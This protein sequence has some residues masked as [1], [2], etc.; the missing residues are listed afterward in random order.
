MPRYIPH[1]CCN[2]GEKWRRLSQHSFNLL[3]LVD[4]SDTATRILLSD[5]EV[6]SILALHMSQGEFCLLLSL[7][8]D[9]CFELQQFFAEKKAPHAVSAGGRKN[10]FLHFDMEYGSKDY[11]D[12]FARQCNTFEF[13]M[14]REL[15]VIDC[16]YDSH[17]YFSI[18]PLPL[19]LFYLSKNSIPVS[20]WRSIYP[21]ATLTLARSLVHYKSN[22]KASQ[23]SFNCGSVEVRDR[24]DCRSSVQ[25][26]VLS[27]HNPNQGLR[28]YYGFSNFTYDLSGPPE[29]MAFFNPNPLQVLSL[30]SGASNWRTTVVEL[31]SSEICLQNLDILLVLIDYFTAYYSSSVY[32]NPFAISSPEGSSH[33]TVGGGG[34]ISSSSHTGGSYSGS[35]VR[36]FFRNPII[37]A[38]RDPNDNNS[39]YLLL[40]STS[41]VSYRYMYDSTRSVKLS[42]QASDVALVLVKQFRKMNRGL[43]GAAGR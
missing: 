7:Y 22:E 40:E 30:Y 23:V 34:S 20:S 27:F 39:Q 11:F 17:G 41:F 13:V 14:S 29:H 26:I 38:L 21:I 10:S 24:M 8:Y 33:Q 5:T 18:D 25:P 32:G 43:R 36:V 42:V 4:G 12:F 28:N 16:L 2:R 15:L 9:N 35:D 37:T 3:C 1:F 31:E 6:P 19:N